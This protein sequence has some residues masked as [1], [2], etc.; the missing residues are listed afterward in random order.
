[1]ARSFSNPPRPREP[2]SDSTKLET[3]LSSAGKSLIVKLSK[4]EEDIIEVPGTEELA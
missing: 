2:Y 3:L 4:D 1:M